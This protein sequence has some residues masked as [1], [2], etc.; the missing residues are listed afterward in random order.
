MKR[1][2]LMFMLIGTTN[3]WTKETNDTLEGYLLNKIDTNYKCTSIDRD[4]VT[5][6][7]NK[8]EIDE[9]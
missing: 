2:L 4:P 1:L 8:V 7:V 6:Y 5:G 9:V 3:D